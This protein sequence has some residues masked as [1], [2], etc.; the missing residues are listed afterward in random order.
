MSELINNRE[1]R[2]EMLKEM[3][4]DLHAGH[5]VAD[6]KDRFREL[7]DH[8]GAT[9]I[10][11][12]EQKLIEEGMPVE[13]IQRLCDVHTAVFKESL[14]QQIQPDSEPGHPLYTFR[15]ENRALSANIDEIKEITQ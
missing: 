13:E 5:S 6:V 2:Q 14:E 10:S 15:E 4:Q 12:L 7:L 11:A 3:I 8:V 1:Y 9:E